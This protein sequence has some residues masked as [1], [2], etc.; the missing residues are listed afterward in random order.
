MNALVHPRLNAELKGVQTLGT[1]KVLSGV[2]NI[3][4]GR[5]CARGAAHN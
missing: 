4:S 2:C 3:V 5:R 1:I